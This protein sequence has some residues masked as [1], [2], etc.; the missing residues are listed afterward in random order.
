MRSGLVVIDQIKLRPLDTGSYPCAQLAW[1]PDAEQLRRQIFN[2][3]LYVGF[4]LD[5]G[6]GHV[7]CR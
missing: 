5:W 3:R 1:L 7:L 4:G 6:A 2:R